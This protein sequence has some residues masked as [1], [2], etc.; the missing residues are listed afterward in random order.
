MRMYPFLYEYPMK[1]G[2]DLGAEFLSGK[3]EDAG[4]LTP[5]KDDNAAWRELC[6]KEC[7]VLVGY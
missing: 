3:A 4:G 2:K 5:A 6:R 7:L 1:S